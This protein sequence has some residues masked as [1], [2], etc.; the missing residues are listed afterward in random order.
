MV[1]VRLSEKTIKK[2]EKLK[3]KLDFL[4]KLFFLNAKK[5]PQ[6]TTMPHTLA[7]FNEDFNDVAVKCMS[8]RPLL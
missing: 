4:K 5:N 3:K 7:K 1:Y 2:I 6:K 8:I